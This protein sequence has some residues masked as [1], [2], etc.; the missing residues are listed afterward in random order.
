MTFDHRTQQSKWTSKG[1]VFLG[2]CIGWTQQEVR[3]WRIHWHSPCG[4]APRQS[5]G[6]KNVHSGSGEVN[7]CP[8][9]FFLTLTFLFLYIQICHY[10]LCFLLVSSRFFSFISPFLPSLGLIFFFIFPSIT[11]SALHFLVLLVVTIEIEYMSLYLCELI[12]S[13]I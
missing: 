2:T 6:W 3:R 4:S 7:E 12:F 5:A 8:T 9:N 13:L 11:L 1:Y 10:V